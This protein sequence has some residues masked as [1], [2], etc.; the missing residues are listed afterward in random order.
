[1]QITLRTTVESDLAIFFI[2]QQHEPAQYMA[3]FMTHEDS[4]DRDSFDF[5]WS[6]LMGSDKVLKRSIEAQGQLIGHIM[7]FDTFDDD[8]IVEREITYWIDHNHWN[9]GIA[10]TALSLF[11]E[12]E[13]IRPLFGRAAKDNIA[14]IRSMEKCGFELI[15]EER[16]FANARG[17]EIDEVVMKLE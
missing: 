12:I 1:M 5:H 3:A 14:S 10:S 2:H 17:E 15:A 6:N 8:G 4:S 7:S 9:K 11:L 13:S 16:G